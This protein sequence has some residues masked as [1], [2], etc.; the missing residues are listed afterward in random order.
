MK[1]RYAL[2]ALF[3]G[4]ILVGTVTP[5]QAQDHHH[6]HRHHHHHHHHS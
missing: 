3:A 2:L 1:F 5:A 4:V 6:H